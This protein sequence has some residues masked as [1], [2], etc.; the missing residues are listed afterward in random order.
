MSWDEALEGIARKLDRD[1][2]HH[3][4][5][6]ASRTRRRDD[7][8]VAPAR[9]SA[10]SST[11][12]DR[13]MPPTSVRSAT[14]RAATRWRGRSASATSPTATAST[15]RPGQEDLG[16]SKFFLFLGTNQAETHPVTFE[17]LLARARDDRRQA[18][19]R[20][21]ATDADGGV[22]RSAPGHSAAHRHGARLRDARAHHR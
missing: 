6:R 8:H 14:T 20:R 17:Y 11:S 1:S 22:R 3:R 5:L 18:R 7:C 9:S 10:A 2:R 15:A 13:R 16:S 21:S 12:T 4:S 19:R